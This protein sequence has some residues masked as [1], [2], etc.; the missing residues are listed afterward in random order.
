M[1][2]CCVEGDNRILLSRYLEH[3]SLAKNL[4]GQRG[5][6]IGIAR[7]LAFLHEEVEPH[8]IHRDIKASNILLDK[9]VAARISDF[10]L[11]KLIPAYMTHVSTKVH[12]YN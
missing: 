5:N 2:G 9:D 10:G 4:L 12:R 3:N 6:T 1:L 7:G 8:I 11:A